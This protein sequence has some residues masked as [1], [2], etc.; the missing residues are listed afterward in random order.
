MSD[1]KK[2]TPDKVRNPKNYEWDPWGHNYIY[3]QVTSN[4]RTFEYVFSL[5][6]DGRSSTLGGD[7]DDMT[8]WTDCGVWLEARHPV[9]AVERILLISASIAGTLLFTKSKSSAR[10]KPTPNK[11]VDATASR[12]VVES[13]SMP[14][15]HH[16]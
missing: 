8:P 1:L 2:L 5:G 11:P 10:I 15:T 14:P 4:D 7:T 12:P 13:T 6:P 3:A 16:L 9:R